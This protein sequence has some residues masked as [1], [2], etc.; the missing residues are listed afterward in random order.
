MKFVYPSLILFCLALFFGCGKKENCA[1]LLNEELTMEER[2]WIIPAAS[3]FLFQNG[4]GDT[5]RVQ[6]TA[7]VYTQQEILVE[8]DCD[9][10]YFRNQ[11]ATQQWQFQQQGAFAMTLQ[12][13]NDAAGSPYLHLKAPNA[14]NFRFNIHNPDYTT[15]V[16]NNDWL[17]NTLADSVA[18]AAGVRKVYYGKQ[19]GILKFE[20]ATGEV[21]ERVLD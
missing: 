2:K 10:D 1:S 13:Y 18:A 9:C 12:H 11:Q 6:V 7:P 20:L 15:I 17:Y 14:A 8:G 16:I 21:W 4:N 5:E 19:Y 3:S